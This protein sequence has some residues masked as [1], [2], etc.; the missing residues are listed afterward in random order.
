MKKII[1]LGAGLVGNSIA[2]DLSKNHN[3]T[4]VDVNK[5]SLKK[6]KKLKIRVI[7]ADVRNKV[8]LKK[9]TSN[10]DLVIGALPG[11]LGFETLKNLIKFKKNVVDISFFS[12]DPFEL[13]LLA[14]KN[15]VIAVVDAGLAPGM[16]NI[17]LGF[18]NNLMKI[19]SFE[20][21]VGGLPIVRHWPFEYKSVFSPIDVIEEYTRPARYVQNN[22]LIIKKAL[23]DPEIINFDNVGS[24]ESWNS[25]G[26]RTL[27]YTMKNIPNMIEKTLRYPG[28]I[29]FLRAIRDTGFF[30]HKEINIKNNSI[31]PIDFTSKLLF[32]NWKMNINDKDFTVMRIRINGTEKN[33]KITY[34]YNLFDKYKNKT[35]SMARTTGFTCNAISNLILQN[36]Y[37]RCGISPPEY[38]GEFMPD[39]KKY[40]IERKVKYKKKILK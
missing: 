4:S 37:Q 1:V 40:L 20:C 8:K 21:L 14:K 17:I 34:E 13:D 18:H 39:I 26:L 36:K 11:F 7:E 6:L 31:K 3:V 33:K 24:L 10:C 15:N 38:L 9:I 16:G 23:S 5:D 30:S 2:E 19:N 27:L 35:T 12:E 25:D 29:N 22:K 32:K 28:T